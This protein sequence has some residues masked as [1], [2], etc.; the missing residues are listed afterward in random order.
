MKK[1][2]NDSKIDFMHF[3]IKLIIIGIILFTVIQ[4]TAGYIIGI[5]YP[6]LAENAS[7]YLTDSMGHSYCGTFFITMLISKSFKSIAAYNTFMD[8]TIIPSPYNYILQG[9]SIINIIIILILIYK[10]FKSAKNKELYKKNTPTFIIILGVLYLINNII[11]ELSYLEIKYLKEYATGFYATTSYYPQ[12]YHIF[13]I[14]VIIISAGL[15]FKHYELNLTKDNTK[16]IDTFIKVLNIL[17]ISIS[18]IFITYRLGIRTY[19]LISTILNKHISIRL[20]FYG[21]MM[22]LPY[23]YALNQSGYLKLVILR[24]IKDLPSF[25]ASF[26]SVILF[27]KILLSCIHNHINTKENIKRIN[28]SL[29]CLLIA[30]IVLNV[31]GLYE[32]NILHQYFT[33]PYKSAVYTIAIRSFCEPLLYGLILYLFKV[34]IKTLPKEN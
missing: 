32:I 22:D 30:S 20:P 25:I 28:I 10:I 6:D 27:S 7:D 3:I 4:L 14:P 9:I 31:L 26:I 23:E 8:K 29:I 15:I 19:E 13:A 2:S 17:I 18:S 12:I 33:E 24:Y 16:K 1:I 21:Y 11:A 34:F 5:I